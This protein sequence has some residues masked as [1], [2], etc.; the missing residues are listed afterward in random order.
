MRVISRN[1]VKNHN[2]A[3]DCWVIIGSKVYD[4]T[5]FIDVHPGGRKIL[6]DAGGT[7]ATENF[8]RFHAVSS[9]LRRFEK[10]LLIGELPPERKE[11]S[12]PNPKIVR[13]S[14]HFGD[15]IPYADPKWYQNWNSPYYTE[16]HRKIRSTIRAFVDK[17]IIP[18]VRTWDEMGK[19]PRKIFK[20]AGKIGLLAG[21]VGPPWPS[22]FVG[23]IG[24]GGTRG[25]DYDYFGEM[26]VQDELARC[27]SGGV[28]WGLI[29][30]LNIGLTPI[31]K[32]GN[33]YHKRL[34]KGALTGEQLTSLAITEPAVGSDVAR[35]ETT[36]RKSPDG[37]FYIV[38]GLKKW[39]TNG[40]Y[41]DFMTA[42]V[43][44]GGPGMSG[45]SVIIIPMD[46]E[47]IK[48]TKMKCQGVWA[49][50]TAY[51]VLE[52]VKVPVENLIGKENDGFKIIM[53]NFNHE[54]WGFV[55]Q[56]NR[57]SRVCIEDSMRWASKRKTFGKT[58]MEHPAIRMKLAKMISK[59]EAVHGWLE[60]VTHQ[61]NTMDAKTQAR[62]LAGPISMMKAHASLT[63][64]FCAREA[65][66]IFG[67][68]GYTRSGEGER[69]ERLYREVRAYAIPGGSEEILLDLGVRQAMKYMPDLL[70][71]L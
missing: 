70:P 68:R 71:K 7:D 46:L 27:G 18:N 15:M 19:I 4:V 43:R 40:T 58:L 60:S 47:G 28:C 48:A 61:M 54:R 34:C 22:E 23:P 31:M 41:C 39:I 56:A 63:F 53:K 52:D 29:E 17:E 3:D 13:D 9:I 57:F 35:L 38:N 67:G 49:S 66:Q 30:G 24:I 8:I 62:E 44:T 59:V 45:I 37:K 12:G 16:T 2:T 11:W 26:I 33:A 10:K 36:A 5:K 1:E 42:A 32:F 65:A 50:G 69:V 64:E 6:L 51:I 14:H 25:E 55:I 21:C 20:K